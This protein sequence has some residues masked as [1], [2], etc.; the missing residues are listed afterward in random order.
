[1]RAAATDTARFAVNA[2]GDTSAAEVFVFMHG[3]PFTDS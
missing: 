3:F 2:D 1:M